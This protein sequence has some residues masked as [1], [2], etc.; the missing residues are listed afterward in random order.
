[1]SKKLKPKDFIE[2]IFVILFFPLFIASCMVEGIWEDIL[3]WACMVDG[4][5]FFRAYWNEV[6][7]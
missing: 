3:H 1:M 6:Y 2:L 7:K 5:M 4:F